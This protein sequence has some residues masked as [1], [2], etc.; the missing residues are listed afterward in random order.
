VANVLWLAR[1]GNRQDFVDPSWAATAER[2]FDPG[3]SF[4][5]LEQAKR[6]A[7]RLSSERIDHIFASPFLRTVETAHFAAELLGLPLKLEP[8]LGEWLNPSWFAREPELFSA[9]ELKRRFPHIDEGYAPV[10]ERLHYPEDE[11]TAVERATYTAERIAAAFDGEVLLVGHGISVSAIVRGLTATR[12]SFGCALCSLSRL[13]RV[14]EADRASASAER[15]RSRFDGAAPEWR[16]ELCA[17]VSHLPA[18]E[19]ADRFA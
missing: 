16:L 15:K 6:L 8:G 2:P 11:A 5:G 13:A 3:L 7:A 10:V 12:A 17:D 18:S 4:D 1:H 9:T 14:T 19:A